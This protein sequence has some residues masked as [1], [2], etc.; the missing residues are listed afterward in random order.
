MAYEI[1]QRKVAGVVVEAN[2]ALA[3]KDFNHG[4]IVLG[5]A[6]L[7]GRVIVEAA[8]NHIQTKELLDVVQDHIVKTIQVG[9]AA[10]GKSLIERE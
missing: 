5:L 7:L 4:E 10:T 8:E 2:R 1:E 6:E 9:N 3:G